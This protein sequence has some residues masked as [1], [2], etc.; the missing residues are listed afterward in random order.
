MSL[1]NNAYL[2]PNATW[3]EDEDTV[4]CPVCASTV[5]HGGGDPQ[6]LME[7]KKHH[8]AWHMNVLNYVDREIARVP[9]FDYRMLSDQ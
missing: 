3:V 7:N 6:R 2:I 5:A 8:Q 4:V 1:K 9:Q